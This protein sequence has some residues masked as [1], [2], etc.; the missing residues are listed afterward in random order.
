MPERGQGCFIRR[1]FRGV[2]EYDTAVWT[3]GDWDNGFD[4][5]LPEEVTHWMPVVDPEEEKK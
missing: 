1:L 2:V 4:Y 3:G 5:I